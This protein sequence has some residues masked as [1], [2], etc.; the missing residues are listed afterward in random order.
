MTLANPAGLWLALL[1]IPVIALHMLRPRRV[2][3]AVSSTFLWRSL[4]RPVAAA[5][6]WDRLRPSIPLI[7]QLLIVALL[8]LGFAQPVRLTDAPLAQHTVFMIDATG[9]MS[10]RD[11]KP[12]RIGEAKSRALSLFD[13]LPAGGKASIVVI[14]RQ[15]QV[16][17]SGSS[18]REEFK[19]A[20]DPIEAT[21]GAGDFAAA[22][23]LA[24][25]L[26]TPADPIGFVL[27]SDGG[28]PQEQRKQIL[29]GTAYERLGD[30]NNNR[31]IVRLSVEPRATAL[32]TRLTIKN[33]GAAL[34]Q[35]VRFDV[36]GATVDSRT[37]K[38]GERESVDVEVDL[39]LGERVE[40]FLEGEDLVSADNHAYAIAHA[41]RAA[42]VLLVTEGNPFLE[43]LLGVLPAFEVE[44][45]S[46]SRSAEGYDVVIY[47]RIDVPADP[48]APYFAIAPPSGAPGISVIGTRERPVLTL[49]QADHPAIAGLDFSSVAI[50][51]TQQFSTSGDT[52]LLGA[53]GAPLLVEGS[54]AGRRFG[55]LGFALGD[56]NLPVQ[57]AFPILFDRVLSSLAG[58][59][60]APPELRVGDQ[61]PLSSPAGIT[62]S[63]P[64]GRE[65]AVTPGSPLPVADR[66]G[67]WTVHIDGKPDIVFAVNA[68]DAEIDTAPVKDLAIAPRETQPG[69]RAPRGEVPLLRWLA[70]LVLA[71]LL[72]EFAFSRRQRGVSRRQ[73][74]VASVARFV[75]VLLLVGVFSDLAIDRP[76]QRVATMF[77]I[78]ASDSMGAI[79]KDEAV[80]WVREALKAQPE[81]ALAGVALFGGDARLDLTMQR[82]ASLSTPAVRVDSTRTD[83]AAALRL[84]GAVLPS[85]A[86]RRIV[87]ISDGRPTQ[88]DATTEI[89]RLR[90]RGVVVEVHPIANAGGA[91]VA[92]ARVD[93]PIL[94]RHGETFTLRATISSTTTADIR[95]ILE[96]DNKVVD[97][98]TVHVEPG[99]KV[100]EFTQLAGDSGIARYAVRIE[101]G[102]TGVP[103]N[104][105][106]YA[107]VPIEGPARVLVVDG[108]SKAQPFIDALRAGGLTVDVVAPAAIPALDQLAT[109]TSTVLV[110]VDANSLSKEQVRS[111]GAASRDLGRGMV[112][113]GGDHSYALGGYLNSELEALLPVVSEVTDP[114][115]RQ[116]VAQVLAI[117]TSGS[118]G[119]CHC[120]EGTQTGPN[121]M[122][123]GG[124]GGMVRGGVNKTDISRAAATRTIQALSKTDE[125]G[126]LAFSTEHRWIIPL[127]ELPAA[128]VV[129]KGLSGMTPAGGTNLSTTLTTAA[130]ALR[131]SKASLKHIILFT[132]GFTNPGV[133]NGLADQAKKLADEGITVSVLATGE[134][135]AQ[136]LKQIADAG[137][138][139]FYPG[140]DLEQVPQIMMQE[141]LT[142]ARDVVNEGEFVPRI[143]SNEAPVRNLTEA[144]PL[145]GYIGTTAKPTAVV[146]MSAGNEDDPLLASWQL[147][148][149]R[150]TSWTS[151]AGSRW[152]QTWT[153]WD[154]YIA[155]WAA[156][157]KDT[158]PSSGSSGAAA[159][160]DVRG[161]TARITVESEQPFGDGATASARLTTPS[162]TG[163]DV[164]LERTSPTTFAAEVPAS[165]VGTYAAGVA[166]S[167][168]DGTLTTTAVGVRS[169]SLEYKPGQADP[170]LLTGLSTRSGGR[171][172]IEPAMAF[173]AA[174][175][176]TG[177]RHIELARWFL[178]TAAL[179][180][181]LAVALGRVAWRRLDPA[182]LPRQTT[183]DDP[184]VAE[185]LRRGRERRAATAVRNPR[186]Q[187]REPGPPRSPPDSIPPP[188]PSPPPAAEQP[189]A[190]SEQDTL[191]RLLSRKREGR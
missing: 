43:E 57:V 137:R 56:S 21:A 142:V 118:M 105:V 79:G 68:A 150:V 64:G 155:F 78:D 33:A 183:S 14:D 143:T 48:G 19:A 191:A 63:A 112:V 102:A 190:A 139:R 168:P 134:G 182:L 74:R 60:T 165:E 151:D 89:D 162:L 71:V 12:D 103:Q 132:D 23:T 127:Q 135:S 66:P 41:S 184:R 146:H 180:L 159:R 10:A 90:E 86:K 98:K 70:V 130:E 154:G 84:A 35:P 80:A 2:P 120:A 138:G 28:L 30:S 107:V 117:D 47:D 87:V 77:L 171:G 73:W 50:A 94:A 44:T 115:R 72:A 113:L 20:L 160:I 141:A 126:V 109:Y 7:L 59:T 153:S 156:V 62:V 49:V 76:A 166:V 175:L 18:S 27:L 32:H 95:L 55:Y 29:A 164:K 114:L 119:A 152:S 83:L 93:A 177:T 174:D 11:G 96:R 54:R 17:L 46:V 187:P 169:Y 125:V 92:V 51:E 31:G 22:F 157:V 110:D 67:F 167:G 144:P 82:D 91:D 179:L 124:P 39:P 129:T 147:G 81:D 128:D 122:P 148:L 34:T 108:S 15:P 61:F 4:S 181:P 101:S 133:L 5:K 189:A 97:E 42:R 104:D 131:K 163:S 188:A 52:V 36:D 37:V 173:D 136:Q 176:R 45:S 53:E 178:L 24:A 149:G 185:L 69:E 65:I 8:A 6:P 123:T 13:Q 106:G 75:V 140:R 38:V 25:G 16:V 88:G 1:A 186:P 3:V 26:E 172:A 116:K 170:D 58:I 99:E 161:E 40:A 145:L 121:G 9:S 85:D 158:F 111:L 100:V